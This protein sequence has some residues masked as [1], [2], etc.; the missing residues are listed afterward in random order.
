MN[1]ALF[2]HYKSLLEQAFTPIFVHDAF[3]TETL[4]EGCR[5]AGVKAVEYTLRRRDANTVIPTQRS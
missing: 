5:L 1:K 2:T 4:L 3:D